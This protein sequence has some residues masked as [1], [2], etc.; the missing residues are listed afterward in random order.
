MSFS[1]PAVSQYGKRS[2]L[3]TFTD[4][5]PMDLSR[6]SNGGDNVT[7][8]GNFDRSQSPPPPPPELLAPPPPPDFLAPPPPPEELAPP[9]P[10]SS[11]NGQPSPSRVEAK[12]KKNT[13]GS[14]Q[15]RKPLSIEELLRKKKA[16]DELA[17]KVRIRQ[18]CIPNDLSSYL[19]I[20]TVFKWL[21]IG[22]V[23]LA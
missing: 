22:Y 18:R 17:A 6:S 16:A 23:Y 8:A 12:K 14:S 1:G 5:S 10:P 19:C 4:S 20:T 2:R 3:K 7:I 13:S 15:D 9:P 11:T 21:L